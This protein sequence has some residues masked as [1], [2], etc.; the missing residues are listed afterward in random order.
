MLN[1]MFTDLD[2]SLAAIVGA[3]SEEKVIWMKFPDLLWP[4]L[5][6]LIDYWFVWLY[7]YSKVIYED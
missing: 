1:F 3:S 7:Y 6:T 2:S 5:F 4:Q